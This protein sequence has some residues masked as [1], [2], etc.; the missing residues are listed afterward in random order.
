MEYQPLQKKEVIK[1]VEGNFPER[2][3]LIQTK[4]WGEGLE[5]QYGDKLNKFNKYPEDA[6]ILFIDP[7]AEVNSKIGQEQ[8]KDEAKDA[9]GILADWD[10]LDK[11]I[12]TLP[13][14]E[15]M[16]IFEES[17]RI[18]EKAHTEDRYLIFGWWRLFFERPW[19]LRG[20]ENIMLDYYINP[21]Q[22]FKLHDALLEYYQKLLK[23]G[24]KE[25]EPDGFWTSD[26][27]GNQEQLMMNPKQFRKFIKPYY[28]EIAKTLKKEDL[29]FWLHSC[30]N[31][32]AILEDLIE[33]G[34]DVF[35]PVQKHT[36]D[37]KKVAEKYGDKLTFLSGFDVQHILQ[38]GTPAEVREEVQ[39]LI[40]TFDRQEGR[41]CLAA[42]NGIVNGTPLENIEAFLDEAY[43]Y[44]RKH[45]QKMNQL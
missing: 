39:F 34:L 4:W 6:V 7:F 11:F 18:A 17:K 5:E 33:V 1:A 12:E 8:E 25:F 44:G 32:T 21:E 29:H 9:A 13:D 2:V 35:H 37:E 45:R 22:V 15:A 36:M 3:P 43:K 40:N 42:G 20:M 24:I 28:K 16:D 31:N 27:L 23:K 26:D 10:N 19:D 41:M 38:E 14:P 30:G